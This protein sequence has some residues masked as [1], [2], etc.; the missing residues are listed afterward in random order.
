MGGLYN[1]FL[2]RLR[3]VLMLSDRGMEDDP[4]TPRDYHDDRETT[5]SPQALVRDLR[6]QAEALPEALRRQ[7]LAAGATVVPALI[8]LLEA[9]LADD[10]AQRAW[11]PFHAVDLLGALGDARAVPILLQ[12]LEHD[13][14]GDGLARRLPRPCARW[15]LRPSR[16]ASRP[17]PRR[18]IRPSVIAWPA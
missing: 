9:A 11:A 7:C 15:A 6:A 17:I 13:D 10:R 4:I 5:A 18:R 14:L 12:C 2:A 1:A 8:A 16:A 3:W